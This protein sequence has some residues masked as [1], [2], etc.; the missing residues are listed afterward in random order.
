MTMTTLN[1]LS[2]ELASLARVAGPSVV[3]IEA[4]RGTPSSGVAWSA[5][6]LVVAAHHALDDD[7]VGVGLP[8]G[9]EAR[10]EVVGRDPSTD[11]ALLRLPAGLPL[12]P[13]AWAATGEAATGELALAL[14]RP[15]RALRAELGLVARTAPEWRTR[16][17]GRLERYLETS[18][19]LRPGLSGALLLAGDGRALG[20][21]TSGLVRGLAMALPVETLRR[22][23]ADL[24]AHGRIRRGY[25]GVATLPVQLPAAAA[26]L[27]GQ[28]GALLVTAVA[29]GSPAERAGLLLGDALLSLAGTPVESPRDLAPVLEP[30]RVG[31]V[32]PVRAWRAGAV[33]EATLTVATR[34]AEE[35][36]GR[37]C[38][39]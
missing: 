17:G 21:V 9:G 3:R 29:P 31:E 30:E 2:H 5:E 4:R 24:L 15:G 33:V 22:V 18:L 38:G 14:S 37:R 23:V 26:P 19:A 32:I 25:L 7:A 10:A 36:P 35:R 27:A 39:P 8:D 28:A 16:S 1:D 20:L 13:P 6:G 11:L 12:A 34:S